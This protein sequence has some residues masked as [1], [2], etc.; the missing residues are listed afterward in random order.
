MALQV[1]LN[2]DSNDARAVSVL[3]FLQSEAQKLHQVANSL[4]NRCAFPPFD[5]LFAIFYS[6]YNII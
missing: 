3:T 6:Q 1:A 2:G 5:V 4:V